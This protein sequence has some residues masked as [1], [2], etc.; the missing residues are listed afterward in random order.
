MK[1][2]ILLFDEPA[3]FDQ[4]ELKAKVQEKNCRN[5]FPEEKKKKALMLLWR[6]PPSH[7]CLQEAPQGPLLLDAFAANIN[8]HAERQDDDDE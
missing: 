6:P 7:L 5:Q 2:L 4:T 1:H 8:G 3:S